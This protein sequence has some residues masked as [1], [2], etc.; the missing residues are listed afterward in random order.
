MSSKGNG[1][2]GVNDGG[3][4]QRDEHFFRNQMESNDFT[5]EAPVIELTGIKHD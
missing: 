5:Q 2:G 4:A 1:N 3:L